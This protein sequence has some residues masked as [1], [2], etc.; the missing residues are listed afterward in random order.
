MMFTQVNGA[1]LWRPSQI[2]NAKGKDVVKDW[3][4]RAN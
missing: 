1:R 4:V 3:G 2:S